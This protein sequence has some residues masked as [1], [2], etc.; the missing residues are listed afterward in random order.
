MSE[1]DNGVLISFGPSDSDNGMVSSYTS[2]RSE[3]NQFLIEPVGSTAGNV[4]AGI[5]GA[6]PGTATTPM[7]NPT[8][9]PSSSQQQH[10]NYYHHHHNQPVLPDVT[11]V[12]PN[13][14]SVTTASTQS[15]STATSQAA[16]AALISNTSPGQ[17][18]Q[19]Q[20]FQHHHHLGQHQQQQ[21]T[22]FV[23]TGSYNQESAP[24][25]KRMD[26]YDS[27]PEY[28]I[29]N[30][31]PE[32]PEFSAVI[33]D[34][35][36]AIESGVLPDRISQ[37]SSGSYFVKAL[38]GQVNN[39]FLNVKLCLLTILFLLNRKLASLSRRM[40]NHMEC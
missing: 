37:G 5:V 24:L 39:I 16:T 36:L 6:C 3:S 7:T 13:I 29:N 28:V 20:N 1:S 35:E 4:T 19:S 34:A 21:S 9:V 8:S 40:K 2:S 12:N 18:Q 14:T 15:N 10:H 17:Q 27:N 32:D 11:I 30:Y 25:L 33:K 31:F 23:S 22:S 38:D 26:T